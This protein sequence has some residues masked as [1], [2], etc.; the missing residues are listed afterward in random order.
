MVEYQMVRSL[1]IYQV[2]KDVT[3]FLALTMV[4]HQKEVAAPTQIQ[5]LL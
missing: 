4:D 5:F 1:V 2:A 3:R